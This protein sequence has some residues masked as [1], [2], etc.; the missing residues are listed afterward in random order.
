M[1]YSKTEQKHSLLRENVIS[2]RRLGWDGTLA[3]ISQ[4]QEGALK[5]A[6]LSTY[7]LLTEEEHEITS[8]Y[9]TESMEEN[10]F[11]LPASFLWDVTL[12][13][14]SAAISLYE[15]AL[16]TPYVDN[17]EEQPVLYLIRKEE[18]CA[19]K[20]TDYGLLPSFSPDGSLLSYLGP[21]DNG[22]ETPLIYLYDLEM[23]D[24]RPLEN[25]IGAVTSFWIDN[26][27]L[28]FTLEKKED[29]YVIMKVCLS[30]GEVEPLFPE[31]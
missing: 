11:I 2:Y 21:K 3:I 18:N 31:G 29:T 25:T 6:S 4:T 5:S 22:D 13:R 28:G 26:D 8:F 17:A 12:N 27:T 7:N 16:I 15:R 1:L 23:R 19:Y 20:I 14:D 24:K 30:S 9:L 10:L